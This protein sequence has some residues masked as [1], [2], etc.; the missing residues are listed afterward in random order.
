[1]MAT[2][3]TL[4]DATAGEM[5]A[6]R[7]PVPSAVFVLAHEDGIFTVRL[8]DDLWYAAFATA[9]L[10]WAFL[11]ATPRAAGSKPLASTLVSLKK[12]HGIRNAGVVLVDADCREIGR[13]V[14]AR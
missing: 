4:V 11:V 2:R 10:A 3:T 9:D 5:P 1:M 7:R 6:F 8:D 14:W 12:R 13:E